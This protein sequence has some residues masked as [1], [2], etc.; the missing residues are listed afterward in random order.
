MMDDKIQKRPGCVRVR[1]LGILSVIWCQ[2][3][4]TVIGRD[5]DNGPQKTGT[6]EGVVTYSGDVP[7]SKVPDNAG[8]KRNLLSVD[9]KS[10]GLRYVLVYFEQNEKN[11]VDSDKPEPQ[12]KEVVSDPI[13]IDQVEHTFV[14][15]LIAI[16]DATKVNFA[17]SDAA[18]HNVRAISF[19]S[20][21]QF[22]VFTGAG[23]E[24]VHQFAAEKKLRP[25]LLSC[26]IHPWMRAWIYVFSHP[27]FAVTDEH[28]KFRI[29]SVPPGHYRLTIRQ[30][31]VGYLKT[32][33]ADV[34][35]GEVTMLE[36]KIS[37]E[38]LK[39]K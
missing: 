17:N 9:R 4:S 27:F 26:D 5:D 28:G 34:K 31:D 7:K 13:V 6:I 14:P 37:H 15:H 25:I 21:N 22:N 35:A 19:E 18:N 32:L 24:Y 3:A 11:Q 36:I 23:G 16:R 12:K 29:G 39:R 2:L 38:R 33:T 20:K 8:Q 1:T 10:R 30:P